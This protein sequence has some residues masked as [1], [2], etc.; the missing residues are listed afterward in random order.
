[1][2]DWHKIANKLGVEIEAWTPPDYGTAD[3]AHFD[4]D[5]WQKDE[6]ALEA[7]VAGLRGIIGNEAYTPPVRAEAPAP[8]PELTPLE[9]VERAK[10]FLAQLDLIA[11]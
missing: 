9:K 10:D 2:S 8:T 7:E 3:R 4:Y 1:M 11:S 6:I 5:K